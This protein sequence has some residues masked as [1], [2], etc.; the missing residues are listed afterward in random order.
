MSHPVKQDHQE[1]E[2]VAK[3]IRPQIEQPSWQLFGHDVRWYL[4]RLDGQHE[5]VA[6]M[7]KSASLKK[8]MRS[9]YLPP[10]TIC[11]CV[12]LIQGSF[13]W[14]V[15]LEGTSESTQRREDE[16]EPQEGPEGREGA[17]VAYQE[18]N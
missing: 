14:S 7:A 1:T 18:L 2:H 6:A 3:N 10:S 9:S 17:I 16:S 5:K 4:G 8:T 11:S 12:S 15:C 13:R